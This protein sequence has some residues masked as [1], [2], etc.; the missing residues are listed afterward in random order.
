[1]LFILLTVALLAWPA[2]LYLWT[3]VRGVPISFRQAALMLLCGAAAL[4]LSG[5]AFW[6][7]MRR[8]VAALERMG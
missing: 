8:G 1:V 2:S 7:P 5:V 4:V 6:L 3:Q